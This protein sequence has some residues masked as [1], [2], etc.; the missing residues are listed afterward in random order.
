MKEFSQKINGFQLGH[1]NGKLQYS[2]GP[3]KRFMGLS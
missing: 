3:E 1:E 2:I